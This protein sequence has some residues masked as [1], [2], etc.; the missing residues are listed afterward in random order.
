[1]ALNPFR[2]AAA[3]SIATGDSVGRMN[4]LDALRGVAIL[5]M[6]LS[7]VLPR[8]LPNWMYHGYY[9]QYA[10][11]D[12][13]IWQRVGN[14]WLFTKNIPVYTWVDWVFPAFLFAMG[15]AIPLA[16]SRRLEA[17]RKRLGLML[18]VLWRGVI[19]IGFAIYVEQ[20]TPNFIGEKA[21]ATA[22][23]L[24]ALFGFAL[25]FP[26]LMRLPR[27][28]PRAAVRMI[29]GMAL[30]GVLIFLA[31]VND[32]RE[33]E[34]KWVYPGGKTSYDIIIL[35]LAWCGTIAALLWLLTPGVLW[36]LMSLGLVVAFLA[37]HQA[38]AV[39]RR[40]FGEL[41]DP[42]MPYLQ[43]PKQWLDLRD[44]VGRD[45]SIY[46]LAPLYD[47]T[48]FKF[49]W[50]TVP[51]VLVGDRLVKYLKDKPGTPSRAR[52]FPASILLLVSVLLGWIGFAYPR[53]LWMELPGDGVLRQAWPIAAAGLIPALAA[54]FI[55]RGDKSAAG[56]LMTWLSFQG[57]LVCLL[58]LLVEPWEGG[59][60]KGP[61]ATLSYYL[62]ALGQSMLFLAAWVAAVD[63]S[64]WGRTLFG[65]VVL[66]GRNP[67]LAYVAIRSV[68]APLVSLPL[69][70]PD[71]PADVGEV[72]E[73]APRR[74]IEQA[75]LRGP[76]ESAPDAVPWPGAAWGAVKTLALGVFAAVLA[77]L[78]LIWKS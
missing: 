4:A 37:H 43:A 65:W 48:W 75:M 20:A 54:G 17:G 63:V 60:S 40:F 66:T 56:R 15:A 33:V 31:W 57:A 73:D 70:P 78:K 72:P 74:S 3:C 55:A 64:C 25:L 34:F 46:N 12:G 67:M 9:P 22:D 7:G 35:L 23:Y 62:Y 24:W 5:A 6:C 1:M 76:F 27:S 21:P 30:I 13:G 69:L 51:G 11:D 52:L 16:M 47:F 77:K 32:Q 68:L 8:F 29:R 71:T 42:L 39:D 45:A 14:P 19:L 38:M 28:W 61:P 49:L 58:G 26:L 10:Q 18:G 36:P 53:G 41:F 50:I 59:I 44:V 2:R